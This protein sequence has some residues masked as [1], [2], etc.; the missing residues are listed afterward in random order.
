[1]YHLHKGP[2]I[3]IAKKQHVKPYDA[4]ELVADRANLKEIKP[5]DLTLFPNL[6][7]LYIPHNHL[8]KLENLNRNFRLKFVDAR[9]NEITEVDFTEQKNL[10]ELYLSQNKLQNLESFLEKI[11]HLKYLHVLDLRDNPLTLENKYRTTVIEAF[12]ELQV[13]DGLDVVRPNQKKKPHPYLRNI[14]R[15]TTVL[16]YVQE[17]PMSAADAVV[18]NKSNAIRRNF[19][20][21][22]KH[23]MEIATAVARKRKEEYENAAQSRIAPLPDHII[24]I[25]NSKNVN[26]PKQITPRRPT[27]RMFIKRPTYVKARE[28]TSME[29][30]T[31][32]LN[33][34]LPSMFDTKIKYFT[35]YPRLKRA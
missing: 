33:K 35:E 14:Q 22:E 15:P 17:R 27:T 30:K 1:M 4:E 25:I 8:K 23:E 3:D 32:A 16:Q 20:R 18:R 13:L 10:N 9:A 26:A 28:L 24:E 5:N 12:P 11:A 21:K 6:Q 31:D 29:Q 19:R 2:F 7:Y 34:D